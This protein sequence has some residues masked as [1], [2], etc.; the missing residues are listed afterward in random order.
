MRKLYFLFPELNIQQGGHTAQMAFLEISKRFCTAEAV[1]YKQ[2]SEGVKYLDDVLMQDAETLQGCIFVIHW[3]PHVSNLLKRLKGLSVVYVAHSTGW[4]FN[5]PT[6]VPILA[7]SRH[8]QSYWATRAPKNPVFYLPNVLAEQFHNNSEPRGIDILVMKRKTSSYVLNEL[9]PRLQSR[10]QVKLIDGWVDD[11]ADEMR[12]SKIFLYDSS[13][14][15]SKQGVSEGF[16]LPP[17]EAMACG[18]QV[19]SSLNHALSDYLE[20]NVNCYQLGVHSTQYDLERILK[21]LDLWVPKHTTDQLV[22]AYRSEKIADR[23]HIIL[24]AVN[25]FFNQF[26]RTRSKSAVEAKAKSSFSP[27]ALISALM[28]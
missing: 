8:T 3:G 11:I 24:P 23:M 13:E 25:E 21:T 26:Q 1:T 7:V 2:K 16:G 9:L 4:G 17:L 15:W 14:H 27:L 12:N 28:P 22:D 18:C 20:P 5:L 10:C 6:T 19:F